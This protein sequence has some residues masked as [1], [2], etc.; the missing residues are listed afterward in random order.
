MFTLKKSDSFK[1]KNTNQIPIVR[2][3][4]LTRKV[5]SFKKLEIEPPKN[6]ENN[7]S[8]D[9]T[10]YKTNDEVTFKNSIRNKYKRKNMEKHN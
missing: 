7:K 8:K 6:I 5:E 1:E 4:H 3:R 10:N 2:T 9:E